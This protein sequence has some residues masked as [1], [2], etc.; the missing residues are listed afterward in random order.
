MNRATAWKRHKYDF[1]DIIDYMIEFRNTSIARRILL[2]R[3]ATY[4][5]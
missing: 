1:I 4:G 3:D 5:K 2:S